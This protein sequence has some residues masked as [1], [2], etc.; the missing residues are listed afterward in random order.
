MAPPTPCTAR[1]RSRTTAFGAIPHTV[2]RRYP[3]ALLVSLDEPIRDPAVHPDRLTHTDALLGM[4][5]A[6]G[7]GLG[8]VQIRH[9]DLTI[10]V[11]GLRGIPSS[12]CHSC[13][14]PAPPRRS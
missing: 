10:R 7:L 12:P 6:I 1:A 2:D 5:R 4:L 9:R 3:R 8:D 11:V 13:G 14:K